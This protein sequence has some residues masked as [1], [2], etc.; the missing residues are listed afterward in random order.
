MYIDRVTFIPIACDRGW[1]GA[2][3]NGICGHCRDVD[4]CSHING[5]CLTGCS[6]GFQGDLCNTSK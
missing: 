4:Q 2:D 5:T 1:Y 6:A 3:C